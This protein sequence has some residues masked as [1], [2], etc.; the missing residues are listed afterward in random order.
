MKNFTEINN[1]TNREQVI[2]LACSSTGLSDTVIGKIY[3]S[4]KN[5]GKTDEE[6]LKYF[7][8]LVEENHKYTSKEFIDELSKITSELTLND[9]EDGKKHQFTL[10]FLQILTDFDNENKLDTVNLLDSI[11]E[12]LV[13]QN[14][15]AKDKLVSIMGL[16]PGEEY[17]Q[18]LN[19]SFNPVLNSENNFNTK[20]LFEGLKDILSKNNRRWGYSNQIKNS[21]N[22]IMNYL[23]EEVKEIELNE[24]LYS[25]DNTQHLIILNEMLSGDVN[26]LYKNSSSIRHLV[27][28][29]QTLVFDMMLLVNKYFNVHDSALEFVN[30]QTYNQYKKA[31]SEFLKLTISSFKGS[32]I[33]S[34]EYKRGFLGE[35]KSNK[36]T[37]NDS[38]YPCNTENEYN[39][40]FSEFDG[41][42]VDKLSQSIESSKFN[43]NIWN[44]SLKSVVDMLNFIKS[45]SG[46]FNLKLRPILREYITKS[47][48]LTASVEKAEASLK[49]IGRY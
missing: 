47:Y 37:D 45:T 25:V 33:I 15:K 40:Y 41:Y 3:E 13:I 23:D 16:V 17:L 14:P 26:P 43:T 32:H 46:D 10:K 48:V 5:L 1:L 18:K 22:T 44:I 6:I 20:L 34:N 36:L 28:D 30:R 11:S 2:S 27:P 42:L 38:V 9:G 49:K 4:E 19:E 12:I 8:T 21:Y 29:I 24:K 35:V 7:E 31:S 39:F